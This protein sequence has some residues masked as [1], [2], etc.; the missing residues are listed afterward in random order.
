MPVAHFL[1]TNLP[2]LG[3]NALWATPSH[4][5]CLRLITGGREHYLQETGGT[6]SKCLR[7]QSIKQK[8]FPCPQFNC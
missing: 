5:Y 7:A 4:A 2:A 8:S 6:M 1:S 3:T